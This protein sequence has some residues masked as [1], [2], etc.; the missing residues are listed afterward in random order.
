MNQ[1]ATIISYYPIGHFLTPYNDISEMPIQPSG[2]D[3]SRGRIVVYPEFAEGLADLDGFS[4]LIII[5]HLHQAQGFALTVTPFLDTNPHGV[6]ATRAPRRP[7]A[8]GF[9]VMELVTIEENIITVNRADVL[10]ETPVLDIKPYVPAF[11][12]WETARIGWLTGKSENARQHRSD[13]RFRS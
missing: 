5:S 9:S 11:D 7:N 3:G 4:H 2:A 1:Q 8:I 13:D 10:N 6:F 12:S